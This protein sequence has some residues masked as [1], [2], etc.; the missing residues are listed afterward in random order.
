MTSFS[1]RM[2]SRGFLT[3]AISA[4]SDMQSNSAVLKDSRATA[5]TMKHLWRPSTT[6]APGTGRQLPGVHGGGG[7]GVAVKICT[8]VRDILVIAQTV[9][10]DSEDR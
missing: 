1:M 6:P 2:L 8:L 9:F 3:I 5:L 4:P 7:G 10:E